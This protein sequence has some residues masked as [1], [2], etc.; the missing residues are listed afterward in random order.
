MASLV[1]EPSDERIDEAA[2][3]INKQNKK[4]IGKT[5][6]FRKMFVIQ[7][8]PKNQRQKYPHQTHQQGLHLRAGQPAFQK[9]CIPFYKKI[10]QPNNQQRPKS[11]SEK[12]GAHGFLQ[13]IK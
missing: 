9:F 2:H 11:N 12:L 1:P 3:R 13:N 4:R 5:E 10:D 8:I 7:R 6:S